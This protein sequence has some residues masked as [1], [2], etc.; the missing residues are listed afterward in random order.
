MIRKMRAR[1]AREKNLF[2][3]PGAPRERDH[4][5]FVKLLL[6]KSNHGMFLKG[7][8]DVAKLGRR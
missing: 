1:V 6:R 2:D 7:R 5:R 4:L 8:L 3:L